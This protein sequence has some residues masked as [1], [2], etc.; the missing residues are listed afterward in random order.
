MIRATNL[1]GTQEQQ[2]DDVWPGGKWTVAVVPNARQYR[3][4]S[5]L[6]LITRTTTSMDKGKENA[7]E[8]VILWNRRSKRITEVKL[9]YSI[10]AVKEP[11]NFLYKSVPFVLSLK[12]RRGYNPLQPDERRVVKVPDAKIAKLIKPL[13]KDGAIN[14]DFIITVSVDE[15]TFEDGTSWR[16]GGG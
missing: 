9:R 15:V 16:G 13:I 8:Q 3:D 5:V 14:G 12:S 10:N 4:P 7:F 11:N 1:S 2:E 6:I